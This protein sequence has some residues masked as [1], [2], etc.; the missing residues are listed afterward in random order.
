MLTL[1][2]NKLQQLLIGTEPDGVAIDLTPGLKI[3][4]SILPEGDR[5][6][7]STWQHIHAECRKRYDPKG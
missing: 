5:D 1:L 7:N 4:K 3:S 2:K 6:F